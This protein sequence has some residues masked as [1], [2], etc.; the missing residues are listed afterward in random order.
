MQ[1][2]FKEYNKLKKA[3]CLFQANLLS[4]TMYYGEK[5][6]KILDNLISR[7]FIDFVGS[8]IHNKSHIM[9]FDTKIKIS[10]IY[11]FEEIIKK[12]SFF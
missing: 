1:K 8:D 4:S 10:E 5:I 9:R 12:N 6:T 7:D 3:G 2:N 11:K